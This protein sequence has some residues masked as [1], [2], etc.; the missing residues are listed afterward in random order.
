[1]GA[2]LRT[3]TS[4]GTSVIRL[5]ELPMNQAIFFANSPLNACMDKAAGGSPECLRFA[6]ILFV[7]PS[8]A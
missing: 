7:F 4:P 3:S 6:L 5:S 8:I 1:V 2:V